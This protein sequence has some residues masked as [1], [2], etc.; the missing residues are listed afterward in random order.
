M[1]FSILQISLFV[2]AVFFVGLVNV[3]N[4]LS[5]VI[6]EDYLT[7]TGKFFIICGIWSIRNDEIIYSETDGWGIDSVRQRILL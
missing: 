3:C 4:V 1:L 7:C 5:F 6:S 2:V